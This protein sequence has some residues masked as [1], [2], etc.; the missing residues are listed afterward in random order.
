MKNSLHSTFLALF[1]ALSIPSIAQHELPS[2]KRIIDSLNQQLDATKDTDTIRVDILN[3]LSY[4]YQGVNY[5]K[6]LEYGEEAERVAVMLGYMKGLAVAYNRIANC[7]W[8]MGRNE[9]AISKTLESAVMADKA[10]W[11]DVLTES[12]RLSSAAYTDVDIAKAEQYGLRAEKM[13]KE[14]NDQKM[15]T[16]IY[17]NMGLLHSKNNNFEPA[18]S[19]YEKAEKLA[20]DIHF[21]FYIPYLLSQS[22]VTL[23]RAGRIKNEEEAIR[24][25][26]A[27]ELAEQQD[28]LFALALTYVHYGDYFQK[29]KNYVEAEK[30]YSKSMAL[31]NQLNLRRILQFNNFSMISLK[32]AQGDFWGA[33]GH[34]KKYY[35]LKQEMMNEVKARQIVEMETK[36]ET[37]KK[38]AQIKLL[39]QEKQIQTIWTYVWIA[40]S[41][42]I[43]L[44][45]AI[46]YRRLAQKNRKAQELLVA[47]RELNLKLKEADQLKSRFFANLSHEFRTPLSLILAPP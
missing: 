12:Y 43:M 21:D 10:G 23:V 13:A 17:A 1:L 33:H 5:Q 18:V 24:Y 45:A 27:I 20:H 35:D 40:G 22:T 15:L 8:M 19:Y 31:A 14:I 36:F 26:Q 30:C 11:K 32:I 2:E 46:I 3:H 34:M 47:Q 37:E 38:E 16:K 25:K 41:L 29:T 39:E 28:N 6:A 7:H 44:A 42:F 4:K 9:L